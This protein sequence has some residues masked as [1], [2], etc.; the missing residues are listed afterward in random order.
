MTTTPTAPA[1]DLYEIGEQHD[2][3]SWLISDWAAGQSSIMQWSDDNVRVGA[4]G[5]IE[6]VLGRSPSGSPRPYQGGEIQGAQIATTGTWGWTVQAPDMQPGAVF[7]LFTYKA[8]WQHQPWVE[9]DFEFVGGDTTQVQ[10]AIHMEDAAGNHITLNDAGQ[11]RAVI[12]LGFDAAEGFHTYEVT[13]TDRSAVFYV[14]GRIVA[15]FSA[16]DMP[17]GIWNIGPMSSYV[18]LWAVAPGQEEWAGRWTDPGEPLVARIAGAEIRPGEYGS[19]VPPGPVVGGPGPTPD[20]VPGFPL[21]PADAPPGSII[22]SAGADRLRGTAAS[23]TMFGL[24]GNDVIDGMAGADR[25]YGMAGDDVYHVDN[26]GDRVIETA[27]GGRD[28]VH[29]GVSHAL[30]AHVEHLVMTGTGRVTGVGNDLANRM[31]GNRADTI[32]RGAGGADTIAGG[33]GAD[34]LFGGNG[35]DVLH[36]G[37]G[38]DMLWGGAGNDTIDGGAGT[39]WVS[40]M[41]QARAARIDLAMTGAQATGHGTD[42][43]RNVENIHG[44]MGRDILMG[45]AR[46]N[47]IR[48]GFGADIL[49]GRQG[50]DRLDGGAGNDSLNGGAGRDQLWGGAGADVFVFGHGAGRDAVMDFQDDIDTIRMIDFGIASLAQA[51]DHAAQ[52]GANVVF[53]LGD[54]DVL[55]VRNMTIDGLGNDLIFV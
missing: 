2:N 40:F 27:N 6:L 33:G 49:H 26:A 37:V 11:R 50:D 22:G 5:A 34:S 52:I 24:S 29:A 30:S 15:Q 9:F 12:D 54:G 55:T 46:A 45:D 16:A 7:G 17:G 25:M 13:V 43:I 36:G 3:D 20:P 39:D 4:D 32:L 28:V 38:D 18:D 41:G 47:V 31:T 42:V 53:D 8:D 51:R 23:D 35:N 48:G 19:S 44:G 14:D 21:F 10:L 1:L